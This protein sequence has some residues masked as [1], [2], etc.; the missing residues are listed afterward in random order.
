M[1]LP[2]QLKDTP[3]RKFVPGFSSSTANIASASDLAS[4]NPHSHCQATDIKA[5]RVSMSS[6]PRNALSRTIFPEQMGPKL[7]GSTPAWAAAASK[8]LAASM[9]AWLGAVKASSTSPVYLVICTSYPRDSI[10]CLVASSR[11]LATSSW[12]TDP[13]AV[14]QRT[15]AL[16][17][18][19][20]KC[21]GPSRGQ[22]E[23]ATVFLKPICSYNAF[24]AVSRSSVSH[25]TALYPRRRATSRHSLVKASPIPRRW[26]DESTH[27][28][29]SSAISS[30]EMPSISS[31][32]SACLPRNGRRAAVPAYSP[33]HLAT[34]STPLFLSAYTPGNVSSS[35]S[36]A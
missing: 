18:R 3:K 35:S 27:S 25:T 34:S 11:E 23:Y 31:T 6:R 29:F 15:F 33:S 28:R 5:W 21:N 9:T 8:S 20:R 16:E 32:P 36:T 4:S 14:M 17:I 13:N 12:P 7:T 10:S 26:N 30:T 1:Y 2:S 19:Y 24:A 22:Y